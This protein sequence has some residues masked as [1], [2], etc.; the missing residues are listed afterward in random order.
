MV[1]INVILAAFNLMPILPLDGGRVITCF[2][3][4]NHPVFMFFERF[5]IIIVI[6]ALMLFKEHVH[7]FILAIAGMILGLIDNLIG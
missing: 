1:Q 4:Q 2:L 5:G 7:G 3:P 6:T